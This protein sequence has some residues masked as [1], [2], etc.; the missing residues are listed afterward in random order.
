ML[1]LKALLSELEFQ[2]ADGLA[3][4]GWNVMVGDAHSTGCE[5]LA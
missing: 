1:I 5:G 4:D 3:C 2:P